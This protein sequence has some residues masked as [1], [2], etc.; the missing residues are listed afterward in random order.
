M[1]SNKLKDI[2]FLQSFGII[3]VVLGHSFPLTMEGVDMHGYEV[4]NH[5]IYSFHMP[6]FMTISGFLF[7]FHGG[8]KTTY[9][10][11]VKKKIV[12]LLFPYVSISTIGFLMKIITNRYAVNPIDIS[13][14]GY[15]KSL[16]YVSKNVIVPMWFLPALFIIFLF[17]P[18]FYKAIT[19][20]SVIK[21]ASITGILIIARLYNPTNIDLF[22]ITNAIIYAIFFWIGCLMGFFKYNL[23]HILNKISVFILSISIFV[24]LNYTNIDKIPIMNHVLCS[25]LTSLAGIFSSFC[26]SKLSVKLQFNPFSL[27]DGYSYQIYLLHTIVQSGINLIFTKILHLN[28]Y[29]SFISM[30]IFGI[31]FPIFITKIITQ[32]QQRFKFDMPS[33][34][35]GLK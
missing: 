22:S 32:P 34:M 10:N 24:I 29:I 21:I 18:L 20:L 28:F 9:L 31:I 17:A 15:I 3:L 19:S 7:A 23:D 4:L 6:L 30:F 12:R 27:I 11:F 25:F 8:M 2:S 14:F 5:I 26:L 33:Y 16:F 35:L 1:K 13:L